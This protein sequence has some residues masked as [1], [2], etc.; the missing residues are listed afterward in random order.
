MPAVT[1]FKAPAITAYKVPYKLGHSDMVQ[2]GV[3]TQKY[4]R[5]IDSVD[6]QILV[7]GLLVDGLQETRFVR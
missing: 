6:D 2:H 4:S 5:Y 7:D 3:V 1:T